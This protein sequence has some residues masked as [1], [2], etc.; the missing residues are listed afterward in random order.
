MK[1][2]KIGYMADGELVTKVVPADTL[3]KAI[4]KCMENDSRMT[5]AVF[6]MLA[7]A[8]DVIS[9]E[10]VKAPISIVDKLKAV[11][12]EVDR[13]HGRIDLT[14]TPDNLEKVWAILD[15]E[16]EMPWGVSASGMDRNGNMW[17]RLV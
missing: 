10:F 2:W 1:N 17:M 9:P 6:S 3:H 15:E 13:V 14:V 11:C 8:T 5:S 4:V 12:V 7:W 16:K